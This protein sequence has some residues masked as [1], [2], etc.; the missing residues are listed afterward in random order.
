M[1]RKNKEFI[2][3]FFF[4][5]IFILQIIG[6]CEIENIFEMSGFCSD[7]KLFSHDKHDFLLSLLNVQTLKKSM[8]LHHLQKI[9]WY[10]RKEILIL[11]FGYITKADK[12]VRVNPISHPTPSAKLL[13]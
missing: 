11:Y 6:K 8:L 13:T 9:A 1:L 4:P 5:F 10:H 3:S 12:N 2:R 7:N